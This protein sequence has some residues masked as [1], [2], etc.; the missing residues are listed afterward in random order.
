MMRSG[1]TGLYL[2]I[3]IWLV[4]GIV[5]FAGQ[6]WLLAQAAT[7]FAY[8]IFAMGL[9]LIWG[10]AGVLSFGQAIF[11][12]AGAYAFSLVT[13]G[14]LP[15]LGTSFVL[16][17]LLAVVVPSLLAAVV[18][19]VTFA[20][21]GLTGAHFAIVTLCAA[22]VAEIAVTRSEFLGG[23]N[24]LF[25]IPPIEIGGEIISLKA[26]YFVMLAVALVIFAGLSL[27]LRSPYATLLQAIRENESRVAHLGYDTRW[28][29]SATFIMSGALSGLAGALYATQFGFVSPTLVGFGLS[30]QVLIW[31]AVGGRSVLMAAFLGALLVPGAEN[32]L[33]S[34]LGT[35]WQLLVGALFVLAVVV[36]QN[37][38]L[39]KVL[40]LPTP[41]RLRPNGEDVG[42]RTNG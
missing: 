29:K 36:S 24:G 22:A 7:Y 15:G 18:A 5:G 1:K 27:L 20:G 19:W 12:G 40:R 4:L 38:V 37:G 2:T 34:K 42:G 39:G 41:A 6:D 13:L 31:V 3:T 26:Q 16:A 35:I 11:F 23:Y 10:Q 32:V 9:S 33:S 8:G 30:T 14:M 28:L 17:L 25:G 21:R